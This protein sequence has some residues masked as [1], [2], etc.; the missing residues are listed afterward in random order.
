M[1]NDWVGAVVDAYGHRSD[2]EESMR[3]RVL[4]D[5]LTLEP[6]GTNDLPLHPELHSWQIYPPSIEKFVGDVYAQAVT[7]LDRPRKEI[8]VFKSEVEKTRVVVKKWKTDGSGG[9][10]WFGRTSEHEEG[11]LVAFT[12]LHACLMRGHEK[13]EAEYTPAI[14]DVNT[15]LEWDVEGVLWGGRISDVEMR[16]TQM[17]HSFPGGGLLSDRVFT[18]LVL[19]FRNMSPSSEVPDA[20]ISESINVQIPIDISRFPLP[21]IRRAHTSLY[22]TLHSKSAKHVYQ[23]QHPDAS[24]EQSQKTKAGKGIVVGRYA[25]VERIRLSHEEGK[26]TTKWEMQTVSDA[27]GNLPSWVQKMGVPGAIAKDVPLALQFIVGKKV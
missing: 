8:G 3:S 15:L 24:A 25:S 18:V 2:S 14:Y 23:N 12:D 7:E 16:L 6:L 13:N 26:E 19:A 4:K 27:G 11:N 9:L 1:S 20:V 21:I 10:T 22:A 5:M 17:H